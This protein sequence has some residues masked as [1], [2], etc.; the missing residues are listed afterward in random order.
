MQEDKGRTKGGQREDKGRTDGGQREDKRRIKGGQ[1]EHKES[2][3]HKTHHR[4]TSTKQ[5]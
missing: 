1:R 5:H 2:D 3:A 4:K